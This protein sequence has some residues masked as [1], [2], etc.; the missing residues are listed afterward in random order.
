MTIDKIMHYLAEIVQKA[1]CLDCYE[2]TTS[3]HKNI[4]MPKNPY[5]I[6][7]LDDL[8]YTG[9]SKQKKIKLITKNFY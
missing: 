8:K 2:Y 4:K 7:T 3:H 5:E 9:L 1:K 6:V